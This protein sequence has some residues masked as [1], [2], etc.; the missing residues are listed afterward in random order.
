M[1]VESLL[2]RVQVNQAKFNDLTARLDQLLAD[3]PSEFVLGIANYVI[4][5]KGSEQFTSGPV[6]R[7]NCKYKGVPVQL[8]EAHNSDEIIAR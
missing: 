1:I 4:L 2:A 7:A 6:D 5:V 8:D 3:S